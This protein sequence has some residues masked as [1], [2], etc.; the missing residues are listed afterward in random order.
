MQC[1]D[2]QFYLRLRRHASDELGAEATAELD[3]HLAGCASCSIISRRMLSFDRS[4]AA[5][6]TDVPI[7][8]GLR[9]KLL[10]QALEHRGAILRRRGYRLA[11]LAAS[12]MMAVGI[13]Y[14]V[15]SASRPTLD[16]Y[17]LAGNA[18]EQFQDPDGAI[19]RWL[20][21]QH[22]PPALPVAFKTD[23]LMSLGTERMQGRDV[24]VAVFGAPN[25][26]GFA[27]LYVFRTDDFQF[28]LRALRDSQSSNTQAR[29]YGGPPGVVFV[30]VY[31]GHD[32]APF[33]Q[34]GSAA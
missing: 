5:A 16:T 34:A 10:A 1:L 22:L 14:G 15:F 33:L 12:V 2:A 6:M 32:L 3:R 7:P 19:K 20:A 21:E 26:R 4:V 23:L 31:T 13:G 8:G 17:T 27:K 11:A 25:E 28:D 29:V 24:P 9:D 18:E 30:V